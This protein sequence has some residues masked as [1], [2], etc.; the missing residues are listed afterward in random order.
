MLFHPDFSEGPVPSTSFQG[1]AAPTATTSA[2]SNDA[3]KD[4]YKMFSPTSPSPTRTMIKEANDHLQLLHQRVAELEG[5]VQE[6]AEALIK[7]DEQLQMRL[8]EQADI[9]D[10][11]IRDLSRSVE[12]YE[13]RVRR[14]EQQCREKESQLESMAHKFTVMEELAAY[15]PLLE[16]LV[17]SLKKLPRCPSSSSSSAPRASSK[18]RSS[19]SNSGRSSARLPPASSSL[20]S[21]GVAAVSTPVATVDGHDKVLNQSLSDLRISRSFSINQNFSMSEDEGEEFS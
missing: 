6:Q 10:A 19:R 2:S 7:K 8:R 12:A 9:K 18:G 16:R 5:T 14:L 15:T 17:T 13:Q 1:A 11:H 4:S 3:L 20:L 21:D